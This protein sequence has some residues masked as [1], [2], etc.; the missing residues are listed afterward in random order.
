MDSIN[1]DQILDEVVCVSLFTLRKDM[2]LSIHPPA[3]YSELSNQSRRR[4]NSRLKT[5]ELLGRIKK[6]YLLLMLCRYD[7]LID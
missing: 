2:N 5:R 7:S 6:N 3:I 4:K 1:K